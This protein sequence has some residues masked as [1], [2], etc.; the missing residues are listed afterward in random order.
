MT[1]P[2]G[3][4]VDIPCPSCTVVEKRPLA[5][6]PPDVHF[7]KTLVTAYGIATDNRIH[8]YL[9]YDEFAGWSTATSLGDGLLPEL[10]VDLQGNLV[11]Y[12]CEQLEDEENVGEELMKA[13]SLVQQ[14][15]EKYGPEALGLVWEEEDEGE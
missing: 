6:I 9:Y 2:T 7:L 11:P 15:L 8:I 5:K 4:V 3:Y 12:R 14:L 1:T 13:R 10:Y